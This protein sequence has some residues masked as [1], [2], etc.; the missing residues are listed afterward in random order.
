MEFIEFKIDL[1]YDSKTLLSSVVSPDS[2]AFCA[3]FSEPSR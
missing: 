3:T 1:F 2:P